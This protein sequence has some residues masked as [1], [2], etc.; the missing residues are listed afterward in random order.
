[1]SEFASLPLLCAIMALTVT[2][3][4]FFSFTVFIR[5][6]IVSQLPLFVVKEKQHSF[7]DFIHTNECRV[8]NV[9]TYFIR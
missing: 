6:V 7:K 2:T 4:P 8:V 1:M 9:F 3:L 5:S